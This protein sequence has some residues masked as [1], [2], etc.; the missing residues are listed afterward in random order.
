DPRPTGARHPDPPAVVEN[1]AAERVVALPNPVVVF[2]QRPVAGADV[3][4]KI[5]PDRVAVRH[6][7]GAVLFVFDPGAVRIERGPKFRERAR[8]SLWH[9]VLRGWRR[10]SLRPGLR[11]RKWLTLRTGRG[12]LR[13]G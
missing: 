9:V 6:P 1:H 4:S 11:R 10:R 13:V 12:R 3:G 5:I 2:S 8:I 7:N